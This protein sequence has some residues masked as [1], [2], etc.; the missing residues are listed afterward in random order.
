L[1][2]R[3]GAWWA[4]V[5][6]D[7][8]K[9]RARLA[10]PRALGISVH[11]WASLLVGAGAVVG[12]MVAPN[13]FTPHASQTAVLGVT[14]LSLAGILAV[15]GRETSFRLALYAAGALVALALTLGARWLGADNVQAFILPPGSYLLLCGALLPADEAVA[16]GERWGAGA[17]LLGS[18]LLLTL[19]TAQ[20]FQLE[21][22]W[23]YA[24]ALAGEALVVAGIGVGMRSRALIV[25]GSAFVVLAALRG[26][27][28]ALST[29]VPVAVVLALA[30]LLVLGAAT[31]LSLRA[32]R[33]S[34]DEHSPARP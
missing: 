15:L 25:V 29:G 17:S 32:R 2:P 7:Q 34:G 16:H 33:G 27:I 1:R 24:V 10:D 9:R 4:E 11:R 21:S 14:L 26:A 23:I 8:G 3:G 18:L 28:L 12:G 22:N 6:R 31:W 19:T 5:A 13:A 30:S 20:S